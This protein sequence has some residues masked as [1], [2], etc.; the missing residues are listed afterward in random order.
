MT[1]IND[2]NQN[3]PQVMVLVVIAWKVDQ[4]SSPTNQ[5]P[6][7]GILIHIKINTQVHHHNIWTLLVSQIMTFGAWMWVEGHGGLC[8]R[9]WI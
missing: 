9:H 2:M 5:Q 4:I 7:R 3:Q 6:T 1:W 8:Q